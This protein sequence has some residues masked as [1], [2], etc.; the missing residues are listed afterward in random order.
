[1][2]EYGAAER[3]GA[4]DASGFEP[5]RPSIP[6][7]EMEEGEFQ[8]INGLAQVTSIAPQFRAADGKEF[9]GA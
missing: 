1:M 5:F 4:A 7:P 2:I 6:V 9:L 8:D 3:F